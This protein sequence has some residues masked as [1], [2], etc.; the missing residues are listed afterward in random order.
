MANVRG[1]IGEL[2]VYVLIDICDGDLGKRQ[3]RLKQNRE[4]AAQTVAKRGKAIIYK[5][6]I[7]KRSTYHLATQGTK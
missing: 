4:N 2:W 7:E 5:V 6:G 3:K 1:L